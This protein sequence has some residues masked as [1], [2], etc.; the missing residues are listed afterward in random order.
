MPM[1]SRAAIPRGATLLIDTALLIYILEGHSL[2][3]RFRSL[4]AQIDAGRY[5]ARSPL[6]C[7]EPERA[8]TTATKAY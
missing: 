8:R 3:E 5:R 2:A 4:F 7:V 6:I 1:V